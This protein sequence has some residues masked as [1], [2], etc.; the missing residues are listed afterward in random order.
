VT[1]AATFF[2]AQGKLAEARA[3]Y[4]AALTKFD[5]LAKE[6]EARQRSGY[7]EVVQ[8]KRDAL[9]AGK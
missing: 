6:D 9:G 4:D 1:C 2:A 8:A 5:A 3:A 7:R